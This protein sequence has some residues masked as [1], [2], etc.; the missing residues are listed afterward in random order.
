ME[1]L[2]VL[3]KMNSYNFT[4]ISKQLFKKNLEK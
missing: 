2:N 1:I 3:T 4:T